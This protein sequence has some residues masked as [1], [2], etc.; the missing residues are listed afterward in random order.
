MTNI[1]RDLKWIRQYPIIISMLWLSSS[2]IL[3]A[4]GPYDYDISNKYTFYTYI[5]FV[6]FALLLGYQSKV[7]TIGCKYSNIINFNNLLLFS[8]AYIVF[9]LLISII[10][11]QSKNFIGFWEAI[12]NSEEAYLAYQQRQGQNI[13]TYIGI[14]FSPFVFAVPVLV[15]FNWRFTNIPTRFLTIFLIIYN[16]IGSIINAVRSGLIFYIII[17]FGS[18]AAAYYSGNIKLRRFEKIATSFISVLIIILTLIYFSLIYSSRGGG[19]SIT[20]NPVI[21]KFP[22]RE[23]IFVKFTPYYLEPLVFGV[24][25]YLTH[26]YYGLSLALKKD[27]KGVGFGFANSMFLHRNFNRITGTNYLDQVSYA[28][29]LSN[30]DGYPVGLFW[31]TIFPWIA[32]DVT[33]VGSL[34]VVFILGRWFAMSWIDCI[35][36]KNPAAILTFVIVSHIIFSLPM[37]NPLQDG[38]GLVRTVFWIMFWK[39]TRLRLNEYL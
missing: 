13:L 39:K 6:F 4:L 32:S 14:I 1:Y 7:K 8:I 33:F 5:I 26:G 16:I 17:I 30:E 3:F 24:T 37:N 10:Q 12:G 19:T 35:Q 22:D 38:S 29:R 9:T 23:N 28:K 27:F 21:G 11:I 36:F 20:Y 31:M 15:I 18:F 2:I 34:F 25:T